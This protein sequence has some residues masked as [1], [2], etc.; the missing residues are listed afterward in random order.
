[1]HAIQLTAMA[2]ALL[3]LAAVAAA[4]SPS[5]AQGDA[6]AGKA[7]F[8]ELKCA[9]CHDPEQFDQAPPLAGVYGR[10]I[11]GAPNWPYCE[12]LKARSGAWDE[13]SLGVFLSDTQAFAPACAMSYHITDAAQ[14]AALIAYLKTLK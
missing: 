3:V 8:A 1:M 6:A 5:L 2:R 9:S 7:A 14:R 4:P 10:K 11:A 13:A 12:A